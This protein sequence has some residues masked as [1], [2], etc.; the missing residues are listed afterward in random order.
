M[1]TTKQA[2]EL[3]KRRLATLLSLPGRISCDSRDSWL[4]AFFAAPSHMPPFAL[5]K[6]SSATEILLQENRV[7]AKTRRVGS[8]TRRFAGGCSQ[9]RRGFWC[10]NRFARFTTTRHLSLPWK[11]PLKLHHKVQSPSPMPKAH[12]SSIASSKRKRSRSTASS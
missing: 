3:R 1:T 9:C 8:R 12:M 2:S 4:S 7:L 6:P 11:I 10:C 5:R